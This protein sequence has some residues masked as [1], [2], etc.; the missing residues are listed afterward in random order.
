MPAL[1]AA[2]SG[3]PITGLVSR[4]RVENTSLGEIRALVRG[5]HGVFHARLTRMIKP[6]FG[7]GGRGLRG[8]SAALSPWSLRRTGDM[9]Y[10]GTLSHPSRPRDTEFCADRRDYSAHNPCGYD[11]HL[12]AGLGLKRIENVAGV[13]DAHLVDGR[14]ARGYECVNE[15]S[16]GG[17]EYGALRARRS[18]FLS[19]HVTPRQ[20]RS[21]RV[22]R[23]RQ[24]GR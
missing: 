1:Y 17:F 23:A 10:R 13:G 20:I 7:N 9:R 8:T 6:A 21:R 3:R 18:F 11:G 5:V 12:F 24:A 15:A 16:G 2:L 22:L 4:I 14:A 19:W